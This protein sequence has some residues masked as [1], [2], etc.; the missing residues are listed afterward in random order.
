MDDN[1]YKSP[2]SDSVP[3]KKRSPPPPIWYWFLLLVPPL[4]LV[5]SSYVD[6]LLRAGGVL[7]VSSI[8]VSIFVAWR[9]CDRLT[10]KSVAFMLFLFIGELYLT[11]IAVSLLG[12]LLP[13]F[14]R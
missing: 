13:S 8:L 2:E 14:G 9:V 4:I 5:V 11:A 3:R 6:R 10:G 12:P 1:P 7:S